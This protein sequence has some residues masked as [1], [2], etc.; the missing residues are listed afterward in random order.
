MTGAAVSGRLTKRR[1]LTTASFALALTA[2]LR[3]RLLPV[4]QDR[5]RTR[6]R[7][8]PAAGRP[9]PGAGPACRGLHPHRGPRAHRLSREAAGGLFQTGVSRKLRMA[10]LP[11]ALVRRGGGGAR[12][13]RTSLRYPC[14]ASA[15]GGNKAAP[16]CGSGS[17]GELAGAAV[18]E[19]ARGPRLGPKRTSATFACAGTAA[20][21]ALFVGTAGASSLPGC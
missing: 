12:R 20:L 11:G 21:P 13:M 14:A 7:P 5:D 18:L 15:S 1:H 10:G 3:R 17:A 2:L 6:R 8:A 4:D 19:M 9:A 16:L